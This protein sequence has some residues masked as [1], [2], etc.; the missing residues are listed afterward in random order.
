MCGITSICKNC[1]TCFTS[2]CN[3]KPSASI[4]LSF[5]LFDIIFL[6]TIALVVE[7]LPRFLI[8]FNKNIHELM[9]FYRI[10]LS[11]G[12]M[13]FLIYLFSNLNERT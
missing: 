1:F 13:H 8:Y 10:S 9:V 12:T 11:L 3:L 7:Y 6:T 2:I 5:L 4:K